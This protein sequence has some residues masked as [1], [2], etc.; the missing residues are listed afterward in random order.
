M[1]KKTPIY[2]RAEGPGRTE[3]R[4]D[5]PGDQVCIENAGVLLTVN[6]VENGIE[7]RWGDK[8]RFAELVPFVPTSYQTVVIS[9][10]VVGRL[11]TPVE[12]EENVPE[13]KPTTG[14]VRRIRS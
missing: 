4:I 11:R 13:P 10:S 7:L 14:R 5:I 12:K 9:K 1:A 6:V 2:R 8:D 3:I